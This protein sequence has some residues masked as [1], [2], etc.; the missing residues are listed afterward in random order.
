MTFATLTA[1]SPDLDETLPG[2][3]KD[4]KNMVPTI[5]GYACAPAGIDAGMNALAS[6]ALS[7]AVL[8]RLDASNRIVIGTK[9]ALYEK[10]GS[11]W[12]DVSRT[13][14]YGASEDFP[15]RFAQFGDAS[16]AVNKS[17]RIQR[18]VSGAFADVAGSPTASV[19]CTVSGFV[20]VGNTND[21]VSDDAD[22]W[23]CSAYLDE[24]DWTPAIATQCTT[25]R[26][27]D[28]PGAITAMRRLGDDVVAYK[29]RS[30]YL[31]RYSGPPEVWRF[32]LVPGEIGCASQEAV[33]DIG[34][35]HLFIGG[36]DV[37][38][39]QAGALPQPIGAGIREWLFGDIEKMYANRIRHSLDR[40]NALVYWFYPRNGA[41]GRLNGCVAYNYKTDKWGVAHM[42]VECAIEHITGGYTWDTLPVTTWDSWPEV[43]YDS[44]FWTSATRVQAYI[45]TDH[46]LY[47]LTG[48][49]AQA[50]FTTGVFGEENRYTLL[51]RATL[52][53]LKRPQSAEMENMYQDHLGGAWMVDSRT[54]EVNGRFDVLRAAPWHKAR[55]TLCG[56]FE[57]TGID[58]VAKPAGVL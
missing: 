20:M 45:G 8:T 54:P 16:L 3:I 4:C 52:R 15:W 14:G 23:W 39:Y 9:T 28:T 26:L 35:A 17:D 21:G 37:Y 38:L 58:V 32:A 2:I 22:R 6:A 25:G 11:A 41:G 46:R 49:A 43:A 36:D 1:F 44:P 18:S 56:D 50:S 19:M 29:D 31:G 27:V 5:R 51:S 47:S 33:V 34:T 42:D 53:Y 13:G 30:M 48:V 40:D 57:I 55:F 10:S 7:A 24:T 12:V